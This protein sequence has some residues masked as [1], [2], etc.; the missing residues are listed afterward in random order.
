MKI[1]THK[2][3][4]LRC[5]LLDQATEAEMAD[6][7][8][9]FLSDDNAFEDIKAVEDELFYEY[10]AND[11]SAAERA[12]F[13]TKFLSTAEGRERLAFAEAFIETTEE[14]SRQTA[15][16]VAEKQTL[17]ASISAF[18][19]L[20]RN[21]TS[22]GMAAVMLLIS[23]GLVFVFIQNRSTRNDVAA[24]Q[25]EFEVLEPAPRPPVETVEPNIVNSNSNDDSSANDNDNRRPEKRD[26]KPTRE[27]T[28]PNR[29]FFALV[30]TPGY[31]VR[32]DG[33]VL[34]PVKLTTSLKNV[35]LYLK[36]TPI[37]DFVSYRAEVRE[38]DSGKVIA[39][40]PAR[41]IKGS[42]RQIYKLNIPARVLKNAD[43]E[44]V[45]IGV[46]ADG[47][48]EEYSTYFFSARK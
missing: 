36:L 3:D 20:S 19:G 24:V 17:V 30:L 41:A 4:I 37:E 33:S 42:Q 40:S 29:S 14:I 35:G 13:E 39:S 1:D 47:A 7:E 10:A 38:L 8:L 9:R 22:F 27:S 26:R 25:T 21:V 12:S 32:S 44:A 11:M 43:Y 15:L 5:Y 6:I 45:I 48:S 16:A 2:T 28:E 23:A 46:K 34:Q 18:L 31:A